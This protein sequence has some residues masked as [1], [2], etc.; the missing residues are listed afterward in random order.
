MAS[1]GNWGGKLGFI[2]AAA[3]SAIGLGNIWKF[4]YITGIHGGGA[5]VLIYL[6]CILIVGLPIMM[7][8]IYFGKMTQKSP[9]GAFEHFETESKGFFHY[10]RA[11]KAMKPFYL[12]GWLGVISAILVLSFYSVVA[13]WAWHYLYLSFR[14]F[15]GT[16]AEVTSLFGKLYVNPYIQLAWHTLMMVVTIWIIS[17]GVSK[18]IEKA[19]KILMPF[20]FI[21]LLGLMF[22]AL[23]LSGGMKAVRFMF[24]PDFSKIDAEGVI[25]ALGHSFFTLSLGMGAMITYGSYLKKDISIVKSSIIISI[26]DTVIALV[27]GV[28]IFSIVFSYGLKATSGPSLIFK[29]LPVIFAKMPGGQIIAIL[30]FILLIFAALTSAISL[31][32]V[33][34]SYFVDEKNWTR[35]KATLILG[36]FIYLLGILSA[37]SSLKIMNESY[38]DF[39]DNITTKY[40]LPVGGLFT[41]LVFAYGID[42]KSKIEELGLKSWVYFLFNWIVRIVTPAVLIFIIL[43]KIGLFKI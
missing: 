2:L 20:L 40:F 33:A 42:H 1:R 32:E 10:H 5:F 25:Q 9:V 12:I 26:L 43:N 11:G 36:F 13:G 22:Y 30:F 18:G 39:F 31:L 27:A 14:G 6:I 4:P 24:Y 15:S 17:K 23:T 8:E 37:I 7:A 41:I 35:K 28:M 3:G 29:T 16:D 38:L 34:V 19:S 21:I